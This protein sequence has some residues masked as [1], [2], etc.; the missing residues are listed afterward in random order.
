MFK[1]LY[2]IVDVGFAIGGDSE[3]KSL[4]LQVHYASVDSFQGNTTKNITS[5][6][7]LH[8]HVEFINFVDTVQC[9][10]IYQVEIIY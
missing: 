10:Y 8:I 9:M 2:F 3:I 7:H 4:V 6:S 5:I 1:N